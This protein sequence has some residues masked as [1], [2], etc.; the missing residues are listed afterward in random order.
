MGNQKSKKYRRQDTTPPRPGQVEYEIQYVKIKLNYISDI[1]KIYGGDALKQSYD[2]A[3]GLSILIEENYRCNRMVFV[4]KLLQELQTLYDEVES[5]YKTDLER[6]KSTQGSSKET[7]DQDD[8]DDDC[9]YPDLVLTPSPPPSPQAACAQESPSQRPQTP[10]A[11]ASQDE[12]IWYSPSTKDKPT[13][14]SSA[15][16]Q[17]SVW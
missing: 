17:P 1:Y 12:G 16:G 15:L 6:Q 14:L 3:E 7:Y 13:N 10:R 5:N 2:T 11:S 4:K 8:D 9:R